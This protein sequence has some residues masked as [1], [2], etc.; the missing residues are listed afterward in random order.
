MKKFFIIVFVIIGVISSIISSCNAPKE[1]WIEDKR[2]C[3]ETINNFLR[4]CNSFNVIS[5]KYCLSTST[6]YNLEA[7]LKSQTFPNKEKENVYAINKIFKDV[8]D[9][10]LKINPNNFP[11]MKIE[12]ISYKKSSTGIDANVNISFTNL[13]EPPKKAKIS[14]VNQNLTTAMYNS[15]WQI[16][17]ITLN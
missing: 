10:K 3:E 13:S 2:Q 6:I 17:I 16:D 9:S 12:V 15:S 11:K 7:E 1:Q 14:L 8:F 5:M 4:A